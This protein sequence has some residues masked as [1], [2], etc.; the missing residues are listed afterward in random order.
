[1]TNFIVENPDSAS[2]TFVMVI[3]PGLD[4]ELFAASCYAIL[5]RQQLAVFY[6]HLF[7]SEDAV[8]LPIRLQVVRHANSTY[9]YVQS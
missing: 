3:C 1:M 9:N 5:M 4:L 8:Y 6:N 7:H 2:Y